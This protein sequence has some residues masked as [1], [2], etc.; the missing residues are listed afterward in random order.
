VFHDIPAAVL[1]RM[2]ELEE[3]DSR[4]RTDGSLQR[5]RLR[6]VPPETGRFLAMLASM[7]PP[8]DCVEIGTSAG[9]STLWLTLAGR[10]RAGR[11]KT[12]EILEEKAEL[13]RQ[14]FERAEV[15]DL[16]DFV[17]GNAFDY[18]P[19]CDEIAFCFL[20]AEKADYQD[21]YNA[22]V[23]RLVPGGILAADN[24]LSHREVLAPFTGR[25]LADDRVDALVI[26]IGSGVL[27]CR[28]GKGD[29]Q[30]TS[31]MSFL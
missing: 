31:E 30:E 26:P 21:Y 7:A 27:V 13:A 8:G 1:D 6:Q 25:A 16:V 5:I 14:T 28:K 12:F 11:I 15:A 3:M 29:S 24:V 10:R 22:I 17:H 2:R 19:D 4:D 23:P 20:D 9:Y 18:I